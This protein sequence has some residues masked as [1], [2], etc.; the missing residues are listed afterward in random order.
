[1]SED[2]IGETP[3]TDPEE[4]E[5]E[6]LFDEHDVCVIHTLSYIDDFREV[7]NK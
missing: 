7:F 3:G 1:M 2:K 5:E 6:G 4:D